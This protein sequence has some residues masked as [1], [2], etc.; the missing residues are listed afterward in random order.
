MLCVDRGALHIYI[1]GF[2][3]IFLF[4]NIFITHI[5]SVLCICMTSNFAFSTVH[6]N[7]NINFSQ[8]NANF[9]QLF[10]DVFAEIILPND[11]RLDDKPTTIRKQN[12]S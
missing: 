8:I 2:Y 12:Y 7:N 10:F 6:I 1:F 11:E 4:D 5:L 9:F 3:K